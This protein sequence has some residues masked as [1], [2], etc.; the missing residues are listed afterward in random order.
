M[1]CSIGS[2]ESLPSA[3]KTIGATNGHEFTRI[4]K[5]LNELKGTVRSILSGC[6]AESGVLRVDLWAC[7]YPVSTV[8]LEE[9]SPPIGTF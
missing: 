1:V 9:P 6:A 4:K 7:G 2:G 3:S 5:A 8:G